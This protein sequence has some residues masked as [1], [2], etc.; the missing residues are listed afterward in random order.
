MLI[1]CGLSQ[2]KFRIIESAQ[3]VRV[4]LGEGQ[5]Q[6]WL[7]IHFIWYAKEEAPLG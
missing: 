5:T 2:V 4:T 6:I 7:E 1:L 3:I